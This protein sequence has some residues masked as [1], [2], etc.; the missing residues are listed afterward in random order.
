MNPHIDLLPDATKSLWLRLCQEPLLKDAILIGGTALTLR[1][2]HRRSEDLDFTFLSEKLPT[3][4]VAV[5]LRSSPIGHAT[6][7]SQAMMSS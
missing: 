7:I 5:L 6:T 3:A 2:G 1:I 4:N